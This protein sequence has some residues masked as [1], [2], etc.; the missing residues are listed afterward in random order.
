MARFELS[1]DLPEGCD[2]VRLQNGEKGW[3][4]CVISYATKDKYEVGIASQFGYAFKQNSPKRAIE[5][6][7]AEARE[8]TNKIKRQRAAGRDPRLPKLSPE[9]ELLVALNLV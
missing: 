7:A 9:E 2:L 4:A 6:A 3:E 1:V 5:I 8:G